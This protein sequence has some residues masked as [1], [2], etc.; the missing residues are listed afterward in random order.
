MSDD[1]NAELEN[2]AAKVVEG[3]THFTLRR[4]DFNLG[5]SVPDFSILQGE[6]KIGVLEVTRV[7]RPEALNLWAGLHKHGTIRLEASERLWVV[8]LASDIVAVKRLV[9][10]LPALL[11]D[12]ELLAGPGEQELVIDESDGFE[13]SAD[14]AALKG[15][16]RTAGIRRCSGITVEDSSP[17]GEIV[18][19][20]RSRVGTL[21]AGL[22]TRDAAVAME[23]SDN[24]FKCSLRPADGNGELFVWL[25]DTPGEMAMTLPRH[26]AVGTDTDAPVLPPEVTRVWVAAPPNVGEN[27][28]RAV[29]SSSGGAWESHP[30]PALG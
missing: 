9:Q 12:I 7:L 19:L 21:H 17:R 4:Q 13:V 25:I 18:I 14:L 16:L 10:I 15:R 20:P 8:W 3:L 5:Q 23:A 29:W 11:R 26:S 2:L 28:P 27:A 24:R 22:V 1:W 30:I 6:R